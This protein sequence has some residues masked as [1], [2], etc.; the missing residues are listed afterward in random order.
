MIY[1]TEN[2]LKTNTLERLL[3]ESVADFQQ[4]KD[5][6]ELQVLAEVKALIS[7]RYDVKAI[8]GT[9]TIRDPFLVKIITKMVVHDI[10]SRNAARK[11]PQDRKEDYEWAMK[12]LEKINTGRLKLDGLPSKP[13]D[14][15]NGGT[16][17]TASKMLYGNLKNKDFYI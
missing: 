3:N 10:I 17:S 4:A 11:I 12:Q 15:T 7:N 14:T 6:V 1:L 9:P 8:F 2:D 13:T 16:S 5:E